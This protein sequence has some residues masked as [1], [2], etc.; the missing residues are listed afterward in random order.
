MANMTQNS[1]RALTALSL[2]LAF[3]LAYGQDNE[4][5]DADPPD[6]AARLSYLQGDV[7]MQPAGEDEW[8]DAMVNRPLTTGDKLWIDQNARAEIHVG[9]AVVRL[10]SNTG[11]S[12]LNVDDDTIQMRMTAG[13]IDVNVHALDGNDQIEV[14]TPN[15]ALSI[16]R[17]GRYRVEVDDNGDTTI[18][19]IS[20]GMADASGGSQSTVVH[21]QTVATFRGYGDFT[22]QLAT[23]GAPD[24]FDSWSLERDRRD[25]RAAY[26]Q[27]AQYVSPDVTG[28]QDLDDN[29]SW[30]SEPEYGYVWTPT[31]VSVGWS[32]YRDGRWAWIAPWGWTWIDDAPWGY[33]PFH[34][35][36]WAH[37][38]E[39][40]CWVP[41]PRHVRAV[42]APALVGWVGGGGVAWFPLGPREVYVPARRFS[43]RYVERVNVTNTIVNRVLIK[44]AYE[45]RDANPRYRNRAV[46]GG[47]TAV[48]R[49]TFTSA[50]HVGNHRVRLDEREIARSNGTA[51][52]PQI[53]PVRESRLGGSARVS[54][55]MPPRAVVAR[56]VIVK[57]PPP[58]ASTRFVRNPETNNAQREQAEV[59][60]TRR[61]RVIDERGTREA[62]SEHNDRP[63]RVQQPNIQP[64]AQP[65]TQPR[66]EREPRAE[67]PRGVVAPP[68]QQSTHDQ[69]GSLRARED[70]PQRV[71]QE[72]MP[73]SQDQQQRQ[74]AEQLQRQQQYHQQR[75]SVDNARASRQ[76]AERPVD[77][78][79]TESRPREVERPRVERPE[80]QQA[81]PEPRQQQSERQQQQPEKVREIKRNRDDEKN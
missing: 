65:N 74:Q 67:V 59:N 43:P 14:D 75:E 51:V 24:E 72:R 6:R 60:R 5:Y 80:R 54:G 48:S 31:R 41:G 22:P 42:Y 18:V 68:A 76:Q 46:A 69:P 20:E 26:S 38:R 17:P 32:P 73:Q 47:V 63:G 25:D 45:H 66:V 29:G 78:Q 81:P 33:A 4:P 50:E 30:S 3:G 16:L 7:S 70:R 58:Q 57:R 53:A 36:R 77:T 49:E 12:F 62:R 56:Q 9:E 64:D 8:A 15:I 61:D 40:W 28:Y 1:L 27:T 44:N 19:K 13:V 23:L 55:R 39:R 52:A 2:C 11:F 21:A 10:G 71:Q 34:Y 79:R 37:V 35:G